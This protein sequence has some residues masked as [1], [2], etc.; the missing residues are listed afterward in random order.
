MA[1]YWYGG[2]DFFL[3]DQGGRDRDMEF[4]PGSRQRVVYLQKAVGWAWAAFDLQREMVERFTVGG[5]FRTIVAVA[6]ASGAI[7]GIFGA[8]QPYPG[9]TGFWDQPTAVEQHVLLLEDL[10]EWPDTVGVEALALR[11][12]ARLDLAFGGSENATWTGRGQT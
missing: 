7:L 9:S 10:A 8:R 1:V 6:H 3:G 5:P 4:P 12:G 2:V 11:F